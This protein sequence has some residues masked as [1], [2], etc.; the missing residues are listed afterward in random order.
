[1]IEVHS[2]LFVGDDIDYIRHVARQAGWAVVHA[3]KLP[4]HKELLGNHT[5][6]APQN[7]PEYYLARRDDVLFLN[8]VDAPQGRFFSKEHL[9]D[10]T[11]SFL[12]EMN[13][14]GMPVL[15]HCNQGESRSPSLA[16]LY[17][18]ARLRALPTESLA[19]AEAAFRPLY[20][21]YS[22]KPGIREHL[23]QYWDQYCGEGA[24][25]IGSTAEGEVTW[26]S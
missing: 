20:P 10:P 7:H 15:I 9:I 22:P 18:A 11:L 25:G 16:L 14:R 19:A 24:R 17:M 6:G 5:A 8:I 1:M 26:V 12:D 3:C 2:G 13:E 23:L 4:Y 21:M